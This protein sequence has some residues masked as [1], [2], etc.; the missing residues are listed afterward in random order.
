M[1]ASEKSMFFCVTV[2]YYAERI[3]HPCQEYS[4][5]LLTHILLDDIYNRINDAFVVILLSYSVSNFKEGYTMIS[6]RKFPIFKILRF[7]SQSLIIVVF[8]AFSLW[9]FLS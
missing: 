2:F 8:S 9:F 3:T 7:C 4:L 1:T 6:G 5:A